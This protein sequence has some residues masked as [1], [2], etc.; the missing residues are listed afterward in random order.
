MIRLTSSEV[1]SYLSRFKADWTG[2]ISQTAEKPF[3]AQVIKLA[4]LR[5]WLVYH[6]HD[7]RR[8]AS[9]FP[10]LVLCRPPRLIFAELKSEKGKPTME[11]VAW[12]DALSGCG[13]EVFC[14]RP[15]DLERVAWILG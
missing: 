1:A 3:M 2:G 6:T 9:G 12:L 11:Q 15:S 10:D 5:N 7:S 14:W 13:V 8:S 4:R